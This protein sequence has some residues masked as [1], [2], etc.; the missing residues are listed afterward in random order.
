M[1]VNSSQLPSYEGNLFALMS[2]KN[3]L[4]GGF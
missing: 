2:T 3:G 1:S 4:K